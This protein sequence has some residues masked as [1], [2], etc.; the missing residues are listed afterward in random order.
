VAPPALPYIAYAIG[1]YDVLLRFPALDDTTAPLIL[2]ESA[3]A[4]P[5]S[6][7]VVSGAA[8][9]IDPA[10]RPAA[11]TMGARWPT[12]VLRVELPLLRAGILT[13]N[14]ADGRPWRRPRPGSAPPP[15]TRRNDRCARRARRSWRS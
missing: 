4:F 14:P 7:L 1:L 10:P 11:S 13:V 15:A 6:F 2:G 8:A 9:R 3:L 5:I 12:I